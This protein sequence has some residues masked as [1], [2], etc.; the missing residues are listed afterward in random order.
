[1]KVIGSINNMLVYRLLILK[2]EFVECKLCNSLIVFIVWVNVTF[3]LILFYGMMLS[4]LCQLQAGGHTLDLISLTAI[5]LTD[6]DSIGLIS[7]TTNCCGYCGQVLKHYAYWYCD[8]RDWYFA[9]ASVM[10]WRRAMEPWI[11][12]L[13]QCEARVKGYIRLLDERLV[14]V[15]RTG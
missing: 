1:M 7:P 2:C 10:N 5:L 14:L 13:S 3:R 4:V 12:S 11:K 15:K 8:I 9:S 6:W